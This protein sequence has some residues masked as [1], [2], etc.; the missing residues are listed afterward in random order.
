MCVRIYVLMYADDVQ[1]YVKNARKI[2][3]VTARPRHKHLRSCITCSPSYDHLEMSKASSVTYDTMFHFH[4]QNRYQSYTKQSKKGARCVLLGSIGLHYK[5]T[6][7]MCAL[8][9]LMA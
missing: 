8:W 1:L 3:F 6:Q 4:V 2:T 5:Y 7:N 9:A